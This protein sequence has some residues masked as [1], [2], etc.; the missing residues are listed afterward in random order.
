MAEMAASDETAEAPVPSYLYCIN[1]GG[2]RPFHRGT[3]AHQ[4]AVAVWIINPPHGGPELVFLQPG[5]GIGGSF[6]RIGM[7]PLIGRN[8]AR[9]VRR[10]LERVVLPIHPPLLDLADLRADRDE[11]I[12]QAIEFGLRLAFCRLNHQRPG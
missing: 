5:C 6:A 1:S 7:S 8:G 2:L 11:G 12:T 4:I 9:G 10:M 3:S